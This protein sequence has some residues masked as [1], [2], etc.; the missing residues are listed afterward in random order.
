MVVQGMTCIRRVF[1]GRE[2]ATTVRVCGLLALLIF[3]GS[4]ALAA[5]DPGTTAPASQ[6]FFYGQKQ[7][8]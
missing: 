1:S 3:Q 2:A 4:A 5:A 7:Q 8:V 6:E